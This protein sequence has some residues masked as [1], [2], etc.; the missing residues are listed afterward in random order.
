MAPQLEL[1]DGK[2]RLRLNTG[3]WHDVEPGWFVVLAS[4]PD[5]RKGET[6]F[7][8]PASEYTVESN[9]GVVTFFARDPLSS[10]YTF[11]WRDI[12]ITEIFPSEPNHLSTRPYTNEDAM[13]IEDVIP[14]GQKEEPKWFITFSLVTSSSAAARKAAQELSSVATD[15][16]TSFTSSAIER[17]TVTTSLDHDDDE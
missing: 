1:I 2:I 17:V 4:H 3:R 5:I 11:N 16:S 8:F 13:R 7:F 14:Q 6:E 10:S 15:L 9:P 12:G